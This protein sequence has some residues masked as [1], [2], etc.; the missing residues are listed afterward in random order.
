MDLR[1]IGIFDSGVGGLTV[2]KRL[3]E[4][5][6]GEDYIYFGDTKRVPYGDRSEEE[7]MGEN[8]KI[9]DPAI[10]LAYDVKD[11]LLKKDLLNPQIRGKAEFFVSGDKDNFIKTAEM[12]LG[13]KIENVLHV[14]IEKY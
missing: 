14:D 4:V 6:P 5:L 7:I 2:L 10:K 1:P 8:V 3:V 11:Y 12:L 9:V 13:E